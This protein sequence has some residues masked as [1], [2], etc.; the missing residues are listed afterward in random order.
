MR[1]ALSRIAM[2]L[3]V[4]FVLGIV[5]QFFSPPPGVGGMVSMTGFVGY[6]IF[7]WLRNIGGKGGTFNDTSS[8]ADRQDRW[9]NY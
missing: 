3:V 1:V 9:R 7:D 2:G 5:A 4:G 6:I 8:T